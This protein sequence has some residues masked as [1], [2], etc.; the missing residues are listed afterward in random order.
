MSDDQRKVN[1]YKLEDEENDFSLGPSFHRPPPSSPKCGGSVIVMS[2]LIMLLNIVHLKTNK[3]KYYSSFSVFIR[4][5]YSIY[6]D[7]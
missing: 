1:K 5:L 3:K 4:I 6:L 2:L 7:I